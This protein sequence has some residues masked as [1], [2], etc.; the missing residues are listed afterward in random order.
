MTAITLWSESGGVGKTTTT[1]HLGAALGRADYDVLLVDLDPQP[2]S[3]TDHA[4]YPDAKTD[5]TRPTVVD[6]LLG[7]ETRLADLRIDDDHYDLVPAH[8]SL[9]SLESTVRSEGISMAEFLLE[10]ALDPLA[11]AYDYV[12]VDPPATL[13]LLVDNALIAT[14]NL[15]IPMELTRKGERSV[16]GVLDTV[17][18][19]ETQLQRARPDF[20][21]T[22]L[23]VVPNKVSGSRLNREIE[24]D[25]ADVPLL[26]VSIPDYNVVE[27]AWDAHLDIFEFDEHP[28]HGLRPYQEQL[29]DAYRD[30]AEIVVDV[31]PPDRPEPRLEGR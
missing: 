7:D 13:N 18:A 8:E 30:L 2:A 16:A 19:L 27:S 1:L 3:L 31:A 17:T 28:D 5:D 21:L 6:A 24:A 11:D 9:A 29:L 22:V 10:S 14:G 20:E 23:G 25:L 4:G 12:L 26:P 15:L